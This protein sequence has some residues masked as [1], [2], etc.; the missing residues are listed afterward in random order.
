[1]LGGAEIYVH[2]DESG[3]LVFSKGSSKVPVI[4][5]QLLED[6]KDLDRITRNMRRS[7][8]K[9]ELQTT[10]EIKANNSCPDLRKH[11][12]YKINSSPVATNFM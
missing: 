3:D 9:R 1:M 5:A 7:K 8:F 12:I 4:S 2:I 10:A 6:S 11:M